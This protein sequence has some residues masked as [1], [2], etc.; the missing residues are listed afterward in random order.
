M[1]SSKLPAKVELRCGKR[2][3]YH[4]LGAVRWFHNHP[5]FLR[6]MH[7][8]PVARMLAAEHFDAQMAAQLRG[9]HDHLWLMRQGKKWMREARLRLRP[10]SPPP[11]SYSVGH[12]SL[13]ECIHGGEGTDAYGTYTGYLQMT[14][15]WE[16]HSGNWYA[17]GTGVY[18]LAEQEYAA[19]GYSIS[20][21]EGQWP[22]T[23]PPCLR[24]AE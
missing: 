11:S 4:G 1:C 20:W 19:H 22:N 21:L 10:P 2:A 17:M 24:Y 18:A 8:T 7:M 6:Q 3:Y 12:E 9:L 23:S 13:W 15:P 14:N 16:G 5:P